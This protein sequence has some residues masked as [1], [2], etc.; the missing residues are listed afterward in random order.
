MIEC[1]ICST[2]I[3]RADN[4]KRHNLSKIHNKNMNK[5]QKDIK[6][7]KNK[8]KAQKNMKLSD[9]IDK[10]VQ[11]KLDE[12]FKVK[13]N[14]SR[15]RRNINDLEGQ[16]L[17]KKQKTIDVPIEIINLENEDEEDTIENIE[18]N[19]ETNNEENNDENSEEENNEENNEEEN[20][21]KNNEEGENVLLE[22]K[23]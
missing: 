1:G 19:N 14:V 6:M 22:G 2:T 15:K 13:K 18:E 7:G 21:E 20:N 4:L 23:F 9:K 8:D 10:L 17:N 16:N 11:K 5:V 3:S 12:M